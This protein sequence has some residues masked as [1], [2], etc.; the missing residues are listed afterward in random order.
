MKPAILVTGGAGYI[1]SS[2]CKALDGA[3]YL[4]VAYDNLSQGHRW[5]VQWG[6][7]EEA[8]LA[9]RDA[10]EAVM[11]RYRIPAVFHLAASSDVAE[12]TVSPQLY[13]QNNVTNTLTLLD[14]MRETGTQTIV[15]SSSGSVYGAPQRIPVAESHP[16][17][18]VSPYGDTKKAVEQALRQRQQDYGL[19][20]VALRY[21][22]AAGTDPDGDAGEDHSPET[23]LIPLAVGAALGQR[24]PLE[25]FGT[26]YPTP[27]GTAVR[28]Y[29]HVSDLADAHIRAQ[30]YLLDGGAGQA[31]NLGAGHGHSVREV[32]DAVEAATGAT[33]IGKPG[34]RRPG[35]PA[36][37]VADPGKA[38]SV[39]GW[40]PAYSDLRTM[41][42]TAVDWH[43]GMRVEKRPEVVE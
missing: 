35:D 14:A 26:N 27:D 13:Y 24:P 34:D 9:D 1:G 4:P 41:V 3:G 10:L 15:F 31:F 42:A 39:L 23:H 38:G 19:K 2:T 29:V 12:S 5:A 33:G 40:T 16:L 22:N 17:D 20:W 21:F 37:L 25:I 11:S 36:V 30:Q 28:D 43:A 6:P 7:L 8:D 32:I 18:P